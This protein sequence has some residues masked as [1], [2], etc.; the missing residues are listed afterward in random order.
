MTRKRCAMENISLYLLVLM[1]PACLGLNYTDLGSRYKCEMPSVSFCAGVVNYKVPLSI[2][3]Q[4]EFIESNLMLYSTALSDNEQDCF[5]PSKR[6]LCQQVFP[7]CDEA[8][9]KVVFGVDSNCRTELQAGCTSET[10]QE[11]NVDVVCSP[12]EFELSGFCQPLREQLS[13]S[14]SAQILGSC[15]LSL[16]TIGDLQLSDWMYH[17]MEV[18]G[19]FMVLGA[20]PSLLCFTNHWWYLCYYGECSGQRVRTIV[21]R[22]DCSSTMDW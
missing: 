11:I 13:G 5:E 21:S 18:F 19:A 17:H 7:K 3:K 8:K 9:N 2:A 1:V 6:A 22:E 15:A 4:V 20:L 12:R 14:S 16:Q 10:L